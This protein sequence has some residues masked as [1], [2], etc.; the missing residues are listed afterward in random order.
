[1]LRDWSY[2][3]GGGGPEKS[4]FCA[5][6]F[7]FGWPTLVWSSQKKY[8]PPCILHRKVVTPS[9]FHQTFKIEVFSFLF[10]CL[11]QIKVGSTRLLCPLPFNLPPVVLWVRH[12]KIG[13]KPSVWWDSPKKW[14][15]KYVVHDCV[16][17]G[18]INWGSLEWLKHWEEHLVPQYIN[19]MKPNDLTSIKHI[20]SQL[21]NL[22]E[23][24]Q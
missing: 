9:K 8:S 6:D 12:Q 11:Y 24:L 22:A 1:M 7:I 15:V 4:Q 13:R 2:S 3:R 10:N 23:E 14:Q 17:S 19:D 16:H 5:H 18:V 20:I 21:K